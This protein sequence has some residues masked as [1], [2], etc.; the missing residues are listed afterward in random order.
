MS[1]KFVFCF[2]EGLEDTDDV[3][4]RKEIPKRVAKKE[5]KMFT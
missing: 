3:H 1:I 5:D 4:Q 2:P